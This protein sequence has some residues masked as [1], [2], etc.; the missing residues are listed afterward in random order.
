MTW[1]QDNSAAIQAV[2]TVVLVLVTIVYVLFTRSLARRAKDQADAA[3]SQ[4]D[5]AKEGWDRTYEDGLETQRQLVKRQAIDHARAELADRLAASRH[6]LHD[7]ASTLDSV[8]DG[9]GGFPEIA[10]LK[11]RR[12]YER[13]VERFDRVGSEASADLD[14]EYLEDYQSVFPFSEKLV[15]AFRDAGHNLGM[16]WNWARLY[17]TRAMKGE[18]APDPVQAKKMTKFM[19]HALWV[20]AALNGLRAQVQRSGY[21]RVFGDA[22]LDSKALAGDSEYLLAGPSGWMLAPNAPDIFSHRDDDPVPRM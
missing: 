15:R 18:V 11:S 1:I 8:Y 13:Y 10:D 9:Q 19:E 16:D 17:A 2:A 4:A 20:A 7:A 21:A 6:Y 3:K 14:L 5:A 22:D 12:L